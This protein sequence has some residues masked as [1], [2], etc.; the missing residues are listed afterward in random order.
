MRGGWGG[1]ED[2]K[3]ERKDEDYEFRDGERINI[4]ERT[5]ERYV[6]V[7]LKKKHL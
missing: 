6:T 7:V 2:W 5:N 1:N 4:K 3:V